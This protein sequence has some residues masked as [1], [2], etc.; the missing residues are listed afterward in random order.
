MPR[1]SAPKSKSRNEIRLAA[2]C[3]LAQA[4]GLKTV[5]MRMANRVASVTIDARATQRIDAASLQL[6]CAFVRDRTSE[7][8]AVSWQCPTPVIEEAARRLGL[9]GLLGFAP[10]GARLP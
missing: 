5:L 1:K 8:R 10:D 3:T 9:R 6:L 4:P 7:G 2:E